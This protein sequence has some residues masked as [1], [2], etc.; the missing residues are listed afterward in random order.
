MDEPGNGG[1]YLQL[2]S[3]WRGLELQGEGRLG[4]LSDGWDL[5]QG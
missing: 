2:Q 5:E 3:Y 4:G 1:V